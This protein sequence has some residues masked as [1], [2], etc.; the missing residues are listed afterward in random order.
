M[1]EES[2]ACCNFN[3]TFKSKHVLIQIYDGKVNQRGQNDS[4]TWINE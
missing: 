1:L 2:Q 4:F 3:N